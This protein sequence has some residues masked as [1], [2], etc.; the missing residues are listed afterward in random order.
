[1][2]SPTCRRER[3]Y[4]SGFVTDEESITV[5]AY[6]GVSATASYTKF[7]LDCRPGATEF[8]NAECIMHN[9]ELRIRFMNA[10]LPVGKK[11]K[12]IQSPFSDRSTILHSAFCILHSA[13]RNALCALRSGSSFFEN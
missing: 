8:F 2:V 13:L 4:V 3:I 12:S 6:R 5:T 9:A 7:P 1:F 11:H 10:V